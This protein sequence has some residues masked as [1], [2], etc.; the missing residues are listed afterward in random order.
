[1]WNFL[2]Y[3]YSSQYL[4]N[5]CTLIE[6]IA[7]PLNFPSGYSLHPDAG[8]AIYCTQKGHLAACYTVA[9]AVGKSNNNYYVI[10]R[11]QEH[12]LCGKTSVKSLFHRWTVTGVQV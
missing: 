4:G 12:G 11:Y 9:G 3:E 8:G 7:H 2:P 1:M 6:S 10:L 5:T